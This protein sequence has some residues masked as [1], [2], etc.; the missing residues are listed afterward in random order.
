M[1]NIP[2]PEVAGQ[3]GAYHPE[4]P[5]NAPN[6]DMPGLTCNLTQHSPDARHYAMGYTWPTQEGTTQP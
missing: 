3:L 6:P 4:P 5:C 2:G 1:I